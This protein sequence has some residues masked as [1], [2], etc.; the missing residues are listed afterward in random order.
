MDQNNN[1]ICYICYNNDHGNVNNYDENEYNDFIQLDCNHKF[2]FNCINI[3]NN[4]ENSKNNYKVNT[5]IYC[6]YCR[7][8]CLFPK[9][10][11]YDGISLFY[12]FTKFKRN[13]C[14]I[15]NCNYKEYPLNHRHCS[16]HREPK[17]NIQDL[18]IIFD[19]LFPFHIIPL[20]FKKKLIYICCYIYQIYGDMK[21][22]D[23]EL[24]YSYKIY[25]YNEFKNFSLYINILYN[26]YIILYNQN[27][28][29]LEY[30]NIL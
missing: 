20:H 10:S 4:I 12:F 9:P 19:R 1:L 26:H 29:L 3:Y 23:N 21:H 5:H 8:K 30:P 6:P 13:N 25:I 24:K 7:K 22:I 16:Y 28:N 11:N 17:Y 15:K 27:Q 18:F 2:H 14:C